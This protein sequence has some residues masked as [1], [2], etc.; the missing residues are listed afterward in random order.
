MM[1]SI[2]LLLMHGFCM[3]SGCMLVCRIGVTG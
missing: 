2:C 3:R 1:I